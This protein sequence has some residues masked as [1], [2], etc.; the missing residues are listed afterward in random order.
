MTSLI[1]EYPLVASIHVPLETT[2]VPMP[3][4]SR[5]IQQVTWRHR[6]Q[7]GC[8][9]A[10][11]LGFTRLLHLLLQCLRWQ[12][13]QKEKT[14]QKKRRADLKLST[15]AKLRSKVKNARVGGFTCKHTTAISFPC[16]APALTT[17]DNPITPTHSMTSCTRSTFDIFFP[18]FFFL[19]HLLHSF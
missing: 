7:R 9:A 8:L 1:S 12:P 10:L 18:R 19:M 14:K 16:L 4:K 13:D 11:R 3:V 15:V 2:Q 5:C 17:S 6:T